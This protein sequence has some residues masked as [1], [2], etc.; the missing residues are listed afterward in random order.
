MIKNTVNIV[1]HSS[2]NADLSLW[3]LFLS[4]DW[5]VQTIIVGL[6]LTSIWSWAIIFDKYL[7][8]NKINRKAKFFEEG[9][10]SG[11][12]LDTVY[13]AIRD[14]SDD[15]F[16]SIFA[17]AMKE[18]RRSNNR[19]SGSQLQQRIAQTMQ[20][21]AARE[22][23]KIEK[24]LSFLA[25]LGPTAPFIGLFATVWGIMHSFQGIAA[26]KNTNLA[27]VAPG[28]AEALFAT[29]VGLIVAIPATIAYNRFNAFL[30]GYATRLE[31]FTIEFCTLISR[32]FDQAA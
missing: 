26:I 15:P 20:V 23:A 16:A 29:A 13:D 10:W 9:L 11:G 30:E 8:F 19:I 21:T 25:S 24:G 6:A 32:Q 28:I 3:G 4:A 12:S 27:V 7:L 17:A 5:I 14:K 2:F 18:W 31:L 22:L 1:E